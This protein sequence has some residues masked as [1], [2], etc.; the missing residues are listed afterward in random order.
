[1]RDLFKR[2]SG[3]SPGP[4]IDRLII[5]RAVA[6]MWTAPPSDSATRRAGT[7]PG[8]LVRA[9]TGEWSLGQG[10]PSDWEIASQWSERGEQDG[11]QFRDPLLAISCFPGFLI[12]ES[13][14]LI[15]PS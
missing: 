15:L 12:N 2:R 1:M 13:D 8:R 4:R 11:L 3:F 10:R 5:L 9:R 14:F 7:P 6:G